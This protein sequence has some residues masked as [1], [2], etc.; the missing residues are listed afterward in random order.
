[1]LDTDQVLGD[2][3]QAPGPG[4]PAR[5]LRQGFLRR[6][7]RGLPLPAQPVELFLAEPDLKRL[8]LERAQVPFQA[9][10]FGFQPADLRLVGRGLRRETGVHLVARLG[11]LQQP[12]RGAAPLLGRP[13]QEARRVGLPQ[14]LLQ[15]QGGGGK[16]LAREGRHL[17]LQILP[18][19]RPAAAVG[20]PRGLAFGDEVPEP[21]G[22][23]L[24]R[25]PA[26]R[27]QAREARFTLL[28]RRLEEL[29][30]V[31]RFGDVQLVAAEEREEFRRV[32]LHAAALE[33]G[34]FGARAEALL[35]LLERAPDH[36]AVR[37][38]EN[39]RHQGL[40]HQHRRVLGSLAERGDEAEREEADRLGERGLPRAVGARYHHPRLQ[41]ELLIVG[42]D[43]ERLE[44][45][46]DSCQRT[47]SMGR[48]SRIAG[49]TRS[50]GSGAE[51]AFAQSPAA[52]NPQLRHFDEWVVATA[53][54][55]SCQ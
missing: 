29:A 27:D 25:S 19:R 4:L 15:A 41:R 48:P 31:E 30:D 6:G 17:P 21:R 2:G 5:P 8:L 49:W 35:R 22:F 39:R 12:G 7:P 1:M 24:G 23:L 47:S 33:P 46:G 20:G 38:R 36:P 45:H 34:A 54:R 44:L 53:S 40:P 16:R 50:R 52:L 3:R 26:G 43:A 10:A 28:R 55:R 18:G 32:P 14:Q 42:L 37:E 13:G 51:R 9:L 11:L